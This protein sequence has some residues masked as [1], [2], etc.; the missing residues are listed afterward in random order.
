[1]LVD[2]VET[3]AMMTSSGV[4][5][6]AEILHVL[7]ERRQSSRQQPSGPH[8]A[9]ADRPLWQRS[10]VAG[11]SI[12][13]CTIHSLSPSDRAVTLAYQE[14][15]QLLPPIPPPRHAPK[16]RLIAQ[17]PN[18][19]AVVLWIHVGDVALLLGSDLEETR[20][21][22]TGWSVIVGSTTRPQ[23]RADVFKIPHHGSR[24]A[25]HPPVWSEMLK[26][27]PMAVLTPFVRGSV[28]LPTTTDTRRIC[29][30]TPHAYATAVPHSGRAMRREAAVDRTIRETV[31]SIRTVPGPQGQVRLRRHAFASSDNN[32]QVHLFGAALPLQ[33]MPQG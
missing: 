22:E 23:D 2:A 26:V 4:K 21:A 20:E 16:A 29:S 27:D 14:I 5:E 9:L 25:D 7:Q 28:S 17:S 15:A 8:W 13:P 18:H 6:F 11:A 12:I 30:H 32:W 19:V 24:N 3:R 1:M 10:P 31:R 33:H